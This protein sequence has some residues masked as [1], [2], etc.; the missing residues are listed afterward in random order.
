MSVD[1][2]WLEKWKAGR[3]GRR[4]GR[5]AIPFNV[6]CE[7]D[8]CRTRATD[9]GYPPFVAQLINQA[10]DYLATVMHDWELRD[11]RMRHLE[12]DPSTFKLPELKESEPGAKDEFDQ[13]REGFEEVRETAGCGGGVVKWILVGLFAMAEISLNYDAVRVL[14]PWLPDLGNLAVAFIVSCMILFIAERAGEALKQEKGWVAGALGVTAAAFVAGFAWYRENVVRERIRQMIADGDLPASAAIASAGVA[15]LAIGILGVVASAAIGYWTAASSDVYAHRLRNMN[16]SKRRLGRIKKRR[17]GYE[18]NIARVRGER[19]RLRNSAYWKAH[20]LINR[21]DRLA[22]FYLQ[23]YNHAAKREDRQAFP[24]RDLPLVIPH[25]LTP[26][27]RK[28]A[29]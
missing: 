11:K 10:Q 6:P 16:E 23:E 9:A 8:A 4:D 28:V 2:F 26:E 17:R 5:A 14:T 7:C 15:S 24:H 13:A 29:V 27:N 18:S 25:E 20:A 12:E 19:E 1:L 22:K 21:V 3:A